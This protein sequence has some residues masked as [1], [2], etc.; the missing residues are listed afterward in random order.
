MLQFPDSDQPSDAARQ[1]AALLNLLAELM[2]T[3]KPDES[4]DLSVQSRSGLSHVLTMAGRQLEHLAGVVC[5]M[6]KEIDTLLEEAE[7]RGA[8]AE[9]PLKEGEQ[10]SDMCPL[11]ELCGE[12]T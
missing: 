12:A 4:M 10:T 7:I 1:A 11:R 3:G 6:E 9:K 8:A 5:R 2:C